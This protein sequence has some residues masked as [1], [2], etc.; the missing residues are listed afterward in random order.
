MDQ[1]D[2]LERNVSSFG[3]HFQKYLHVIKKNKDAL[4]DALESSGNLMQVHLWRSS[5]SPEDEM[6]IIG[7]L[8][9]D[10]HTKV[11]HMSCYYAL[12]FL[13]MNFRNLD[14]LE[15]GIT[16]KKNV[17]EEY[18]NFITQIGNDFRR[19]TKIYIQNLF[20]IYI[21]EEKRPEFFLISVGS[22][23]DQ[24]DIDVGVI[25]EEDADVAELN[26]AI[27][28]I[29]QNMLVYATPFHSYLSEHVGKQLYTTTISEYTRI[30]QKRIQ[31]VIISTELLNAKIIMG[32]TRLF[33]KFHKEV[34]SNYY[35]HH[36]KDVRYH[37][38]F[39]RGILGE[40]RSLLIMPL[41]QDTISPKDDAIRIIKLLLYA[42]RT[43]F[44]IKELTSW[45]ILTAL[46]KREPK[47][48]SEYE[49][50]YRATSFM[51]LFKFLLQMFI[52][53]E[54]TFRLSEIESNQLDLIAQKMGYEPI[55]TISAWDQL[56]T[57]YYRYV[58]E[59]RRV[60]D[61][62]IKDVSNHLA[63][64]SIIIKKLKSSQSMT[65]KRNLARDFML[66]AQF[67]RGTK[68]WEDMLGLLETDDKLLNDFLEG[69]NILP[70]NKKN[71]LIK[72]Y[73][74]WA[75][76]SPTT[77][78]RFITIIGKKQ[79]NMVDD[80]LFQKLNLTFL[81]YFGALPD[82]TE[83]ICRIFSLYPQYIHQYL[84]YIPESHNELLDKIIELPVI[85]DKLKEYQDQLR[86]L[87]KIH[88]WSSQ[89][90]H[91][92]FHRVIL[93]H[94]EYLTALT[95]TAQLSKISSGLLAM[96][97]RYTSL[98]EKKKALG[99]YYDLEF[100]RVGIGTV[101]GVEL[102]TTN[103]EFTEFCDNY[104]QKLVDICIEEVEDE[105]H[106]E[107]VS[108]D[109]F[110]IL[111]AGG[112]ARGQAYDDDY[113]LI[114]VIDTDDEDVHRWA[115]RVVA[116]MNREIV[117][118]GVIPHYRIGEILGSYVNSLDSITEYINSDDVDTFI[119]LSQLLAARLI[120]GSEAMR[121]TINE[122]ILDRLIFQNKNNY[123]K[124]M[125]SEVRNR[126]QNQIVYSEEDVCN[127][128]ETRGGL[129]D[130]EAVALMLK[131]YLGIFA[132]ITHL[133]FR[134]IKPQMPDIADSLERIADSVL[135]LRTIRNLY[136]ITIAAD[137]NLQY[138]YFQKLANIYLSSGL[139][140]WD[141]SLFLKIQIGD[142][143]DQSAKACEEIIYYLLD[144]IK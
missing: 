7:N 29:A 88:K 22:R 62:L 33:K 13:H 107:P 73:V 18:K 68:Y 97:D 28:K 20:D 31:N 111:A 38:R 140:D 70:E 126:H 63:S 124:R 91:R 128:K 102:N 46:I 118:R 12:Q 86:E 60:C 109:K 19:L 138:I 82:T 69:F 3:N 123:I 108:T 25:V 115:I 101:R 95:K 10:N 41:Q 11:L 106:T 122:K 52:V 26:S 130:I 93:N 87:F 80:S 9:T 2:Q 79:Q 76:Y 103:K 134:E 17:I 135:F 51:E 65:P 24:D 83:K 30:I 92:Y 121:N 42:K 4:I 6:K 40:T 100:L 56:I 71:N 143:L 47:L 67:F 43:A 94:P 1:F 104:I 127:L 137:D 90:F 5:F 37:E 57:D 50:L 75:K 119:D 58:K 117:K 142:S 78:I 81:E 72:K 55:G 110:A 32:S 14:I 125:V 21:P 15:L 85:D 98:N 99:N 136:R 48:R 105:T 96:V 34:I 112:H 144:K 59:V 39:L 129:R 133:F 77:I 44:N 64:V 54:E 114:A 84:Q 113:D 53:Q 16:S 61:F 45:S 132:P 36:K 35:Y 131:A 74:E 66:T 116:K 120:V 139:R 89:Y 8:A 49:I 27:Q 141:G 23:S